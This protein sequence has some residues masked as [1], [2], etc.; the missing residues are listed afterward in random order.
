M[1][2][3]RILGWLGSVR[4]TYGW[5]IIPFRFNTNTI[6][7]FLY[8]SI[9]KQIKHSS[10]NHRIYLAN[11]NCHQTQNTPRHTLDNQFQTEPLFYSIK[12]VLIFIFIL[13]R[14]LC[15]AQYINSIGK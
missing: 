6:D 5:F 2:N 12:C 15:E 14:S 11:K 9:L 1:Q 7:R 13:L 10:S 8:I 3:H 4:F